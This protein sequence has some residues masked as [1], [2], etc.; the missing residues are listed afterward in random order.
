VPTSGG[1]WLG[2]RSRSRAAQHTSPSERTVTKSQSMGHCRWS[3]KGFVSNRQLG[4]RE[5]RHISGGIHGLL[6]MRYSAGL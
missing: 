3:A 4:N 6:S 2:V 5:L 1:R